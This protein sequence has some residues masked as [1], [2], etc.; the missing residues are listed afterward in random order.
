MAQLTQLNCWGLMKLVEQHTNSKTIS[1]YVHNF[2]IHV[3]IISILYI[4]LNNVC[5]LRHVVVIHS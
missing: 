3:A 4:L 5:S 2:R 1:R